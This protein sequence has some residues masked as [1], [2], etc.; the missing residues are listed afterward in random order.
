MGI[1][2]ATESFTYDVAG[3]PVIVRKDELW[4]DTDAVVKKFPQ[5]FTEPDVKRSPAAPP[6]PARRAGAVETQT[7]AP[8][9]RRTLSRPEQPPAAAKGGTK[10]AAAAEPGEV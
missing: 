10:K 6:R 5:H 2:K 7:A 9:E 1:V 3:R 4:D 8:G